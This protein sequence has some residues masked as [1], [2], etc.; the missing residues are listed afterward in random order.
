MKAF[1]HDR[2]YHVDHLVYGFDWASLGA[3]TVVDVGG[4]H[5]QTCVALAEKYT[6]LSFVV[7]DLPNV[8]QGRDS[9]ALEGLEKRIRFMEHDF[10]TEQLVK[11]AD[12]YLLR[13]IIQDWSDEHALRIL[14]ALKPALRKGAKVVV[15]DTFMPA[16]GSVPLWTERRLRYVSASASCHVVECDQWLMLL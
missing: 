13:K 15:Q 4:G 12:I 6:D 3:G 8:I 7:Q 9:A 2:T 11:D 1:Q 5:G 10:F 16:P 14:A